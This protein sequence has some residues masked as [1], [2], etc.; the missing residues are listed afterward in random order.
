MALGQLHGLHVDLGVLP[1]LG[2]DQAGEQQF[3][4]PLRQTVAA[5]RLVLEQ[6]VLELVVLAKAGIGRN[7]GHLCQPSIER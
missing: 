5:Q 3:E 4:Q 2:I 7:I 6:G 1:D